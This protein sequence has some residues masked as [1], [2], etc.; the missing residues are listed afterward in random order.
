VGARNHRRLD[1]LGARAVRGR[2]GARPPAPL[3]AVRLPCGFSCRARAWRLMGAA[4]GPVKR[5]ARWA[6]AQRQRRLWRVCWIE[7]GCR[8]GCRRGR[9]HRTRIWT[10]SGAGRGDWAGGRRAFQAARAAARLVSNPIR[11]ATRPAACRGPC[12][13]N[14]GPGPDSRAPCARECAHPHSETPARW[15][16]VYKLNCTK[17]YKLSECDSESYHLLPGKTRARGRSGRSAGRR[18]HEPLRV[19]ARAARVLARGP[20]AGGA[21]QPPC[22]S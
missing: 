16:K 12:G 1:A 21:G 9:R 4:A 7:R 5:L 2:Q 19:A 13:P 17:V 14:G 22:S 8:R 3:P 11:G 18:M 15:A 20:G 6:R 10:R